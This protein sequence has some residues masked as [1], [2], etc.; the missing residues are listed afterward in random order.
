MTKKLL[1]IG[2][3]YGGLGGAWWARKAGH[4]VEIIEAT[5]RPGGRAINVEFEGDRAP[6]GAQFF[7]RNYS[8]T[9]ELME[10]VGVGAERYR[11]SKA[12]TVLRPEGPLDIKNKLGARHLLGWGGRLS[13]AWFGARYA[14]RAATYPVH[15]YSG[16]VLDLDDRLLSDTEGSLDKR[17]WDYVVGAGAYG[18]NGCLPAHTSLLHFLRL[19]NMSNS[20]EFI[21][22]GGT[23][24]FAAKIAEQLPVEYEK[25]AKQLIVEN[26]RVVGAELEDGTTRKADHVL[27]ATPGHAAGALMPNELADLKGRLTDAPVVPYVVLTFFLDRRPQGDTGAY[28]DPYGPNFRTAI[29]VQ[30]PTLSGL[31]TYNMLSGYPRVLEQYDES[32][33]VLLKQ[34]VDM[35]ERCMPGFQQSWV[36][37]AVVTRHPWGLGRFPPG[38]YKRHWELQC[39]ADEQPGLSLA[40]VCGTHIEAT[41]RRARAGVE[42]MERE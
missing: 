1:V 12:I 6:G 33:D 8:V 17:F 40:D 28:F 26:G 2:A 14:S 20:S 31:A 38:Q 18:F 21:V 27:V 16:N 22:P 29:L 24:G 9:Q 10:E 4:D 41:L 42:S 3:G 23:A 25:Q 39:A 15:E 11:V 7:H 36:R 30:D 13:A 34:G 32:D 5:D 35:L 37:N 19:A